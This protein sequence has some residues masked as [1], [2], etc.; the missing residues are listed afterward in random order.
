MTMTEQD[1]INILYDPNTP[2]SVYEELLKNSWNPSK[3][4]KLV[5]ERILFSQVHN[6]TQISELL[7]L[8]SQSDI[9]LD[10]ADSTELYKKNVNVYCFPPQ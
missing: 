2:I 7:D 1:I 4:L 6:T 3:L 9:D 8:L 5:V 10:C